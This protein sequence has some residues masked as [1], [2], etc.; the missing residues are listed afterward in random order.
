MQAGSKVE[1]TERNRNAS[2]R[3]KEEEA[4]EASR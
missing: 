2:V 1:L 4:V 3:K